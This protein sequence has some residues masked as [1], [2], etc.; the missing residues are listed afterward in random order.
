M[1]QGE[2]KTIRQVSEGSYKEKGSKFF[3][4][5][6]PVCNEAEI[7]GILDDLKKKYHDARHHCYAWCLGPDRE[8]YRA[9]DAGEPA[10][11]AGAPILGQIRS[12]DLTNILIVVI[13]YF[14]GTKLG[15]PGLIRAYRASAASALDNAEIITTSVTFNY[16][17]NFTYPVLDNVMKIIKTENIKISQQ[18]FEME[19]TIMVSIRQADKERIINKL[20]AIETMEIDFLEDI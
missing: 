2:Y 15:I 10:N 12:S 5:A 4:F 9:N 7:K 11:S 16:K 1:S 8:H 20:K 13:R 19:C 17:L 18:V 6:F 3:S 14:G